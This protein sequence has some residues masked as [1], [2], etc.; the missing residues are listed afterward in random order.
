[1]RAWMLAVLVLLVMVGGA[2]ASVDFT[3]TFESYTTGDLAGQGGWIKDSGLIS[4]STGG[5]YADVTSNSYGYRRPLGGECPNDATMFF[6]GEFYFYGGFYYPE[7][8]FGLADERPTPQGAGVIIQAAG[9]NIYIRCGALPTPTNNVLYYGAYDNTKI[10]VVEYVHDGETG[11][12][13]YLNF[14]NPDLSF[15]EKSGGFTDHGIDNFL[16]KRAVNVYPA[17]DII[18]MY[19]ICIIEQVSPTT[20]IILLDTSK[21]MITGAQV[22]I[23]DCT[24]NTYIQKYEECVD[25]IL[26]V[27]EPPDTELQ[28]A[29][30]TFD[31]VFV[32]HVTVDSNYSVKNITIP[33]NYNV[34]I[35]PVDQAGM[36]I[37]DVFAGLSEYTPLNPGAFWGMDLSDR[38]YVPVTNCSGFSMC[39]IIA[40]KDGYADYSVDALNWTSKSALVKDYRH[41]I[42]M[43]K[44]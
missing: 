4:V 40:E 7:I 19:H 32:E 27:N 15:G 36:P 5:T 38:G 6:Y 3:E 13:E 1:M 22:S 23:Y 39:N 10:T 8:I 12:F 29:V 14:T 20:Y 42:V 34:D 21:N 24:D 30:R 2:S 44:E 43:E 9:P 33:I 26:Y 37:F 11:K 18:Q 16:I 31:G 41:N 25:G 28:L 17:Y 35:Y